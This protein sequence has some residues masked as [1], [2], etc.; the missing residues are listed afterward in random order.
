M[1]TIK[2]PEEIAIMAQAGQ[3]LAKI[4]RELKAEVKPGLT[5][6]ELDK[7]AEELILKS[8]AKPAFKG[9]GGFPNSLCTSI[10]EQIVHGVPSKRE[11]KE[12]DILS[13]DLGLIY[14]DFYSD[15]AVTLAIGSVSPEVR[16]LIQVTQ[17][18][19]RRA[20]AC[21]KSGKTIGDISFTIQKYAQ[22]QGF[23]VVRELCGHGVGCQLHE[24]PDIPNFGRRHK[25]PKI[26]T[27][28]VLA[29]EPMVVLGQPGIKK[30]PDGFCYQTA[31]NSLSA[32]FE[33]TIAVIGQGARILT[34]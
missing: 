17:T 15:M 32:H 23:Q 33:H 22:A 10:N 24:S 3:M 21:A 13:L 5:T 28:M 1:I 29:I 26:E 31:D 9:Y 30:G 27:G 20:I 6:Q 2:T 19:L 25:G 14:K 34:K 16:R 7:L 8:G 11:L 18:A 12:G 4:I